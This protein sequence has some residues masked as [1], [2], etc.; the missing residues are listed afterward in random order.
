MVGTPDVPKAVLRKSRRSRRPA[1]AYNFTRALL[2]RW[3]AGERASLWA[4]LRESE[5]T[6]ERKQRSE[7]QRLDEQ[8]NRLVA[9][10]RPGQAI[11]RLTSPGLALDTET[12][13][14]K[15]LA[16]FPHFDHA[17]APL[18]LEPPLS[19]EVEADQ[20]VRALKSFKRGIGPG[21]TGLRADFLRQVV[22][23]SATKPSSPSYVTWFSCWPTVAPRVGS[24]DGWE[25]AR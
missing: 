4:E 20:I 17:S 9:A 3:Q 25:G 6:G 18:R 23:N 14:Q 8:T 12:V 2:L 13:R 16:K 24:D 10:G 5:P 19:I 1:Q 22:G 21:P 11:A 7:Q 15:L